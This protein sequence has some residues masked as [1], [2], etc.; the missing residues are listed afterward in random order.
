MVESFIYTLITSP[1]N[2]WFWFHT[3]GSLYI[4]MHESSE[5]YTSESHTACTSTL[6]A[7]TLLYACILRYTESVLIL[8][9][10]ILN[11]SACMKRVSF[12]E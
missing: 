5:L 1:S 6:Y 12:C 7:L 8:N 4:D 11:V 10:N 2:C 3:I 9:V